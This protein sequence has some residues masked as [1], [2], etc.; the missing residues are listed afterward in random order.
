MVAL[1]QKNRKKKGGKATVKDKTRK[2]ILREVEE[3]IKAIVK[4]LLERLMR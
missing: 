4:K 3:R 1:P 2:E